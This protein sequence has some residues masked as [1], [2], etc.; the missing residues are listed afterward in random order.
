MTATVNDTQELDALET[1]P[2]RTSTNE[3]RCDAC[4]AR[5]YW[6]VHME[7]GSLVF[8]NHHYNRFNKKFADR[9]VISIDWNDGYLAVDYSRKSNGAFA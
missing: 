5:A 6:E 1:A 7:S 2:K 8:C 9:P 3:D 4:A